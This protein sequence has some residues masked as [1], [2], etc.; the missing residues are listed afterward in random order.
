MKKLGL[1]VL[2]ASATLLWTARTSLAVSACAQQARADHATCLQGCSDDFQ[3]ALALCKNVDPAC[4]AACRAGHDACIGSIN[5]I[6]QTGQLPDGTTLP[7]CPGGTNQCDSNFQTSRQACIDA[8]CQKGPGQCS[9]CN[10]D[11][12]CQDC[13]DNAQI[14]HFVCADACR[15]SWRPLVKGDRKACYA[16]LKA[17]MKACPPPP[18]N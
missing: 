15:D 11:T 18:A 12:T 13:V 6:L 3:T 5:A 14:A 7:N 9:S 8:A 10:G 2:L 16:S 4:A 17:C 1:T